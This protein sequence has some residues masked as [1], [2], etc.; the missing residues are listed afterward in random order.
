LNG[1]DC[2]MIANAT[3]A[4]RRE[5][6]KFLRARR[7]AC[8]L[9][10]YGISDSARR[11]T[12]GLRREEVASRAGVSITWYTHLEQGRD[13]GVSAQVLDSIADALRLDD[14]SRLH[15]YHL[16]E[17]TPPGQGSSDAPLAAGPA[18]SAL[19]DAL[20][21]NPA[22]VINHCWDIL[23]WNRS[24]AA[25]IVDPETV[26]AAKRN[27]LWLLFASPRMRELYDSWEDQARRMI[28]VFRAIAG[29]R[30]VDS[31][32]AEVVSALSAESPEFR[33][34]WPRQDVAVFESRPHKLLHPEAG[35]I[36]VRDMML[37]LSESPGVSMLAHLAL[38]AEDRE[39]L[40]DLCGA[41][42]AQ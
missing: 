34:W 14:T 36:A 12:P 2:T 4:R 33:A 39:K 10:R 42:S 22:M 15:M 25:L 9:A 18:S 11:R 1:E 8:N 13:V 31:R 35:P 17:R 38:T 37:D 41:A 3:R 19:V 20:E 5:L 26:C 32:I 30:I 24:T 7:H 28:G 29:S 16:A 6:G 27:V 21:P 40:R 23:E